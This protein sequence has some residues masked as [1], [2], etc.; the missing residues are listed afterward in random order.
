VNHNFLQTLSYYRRMSAAAEARTIRVYDL[1]D[2]FGDRQ[3]DA[4]RP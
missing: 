4:T 1:G 2:W 3:G